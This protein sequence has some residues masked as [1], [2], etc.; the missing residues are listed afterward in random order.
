MPHSAAL[1]F[2]L[3]RSSDVFSGAGKRLAGGADSGGS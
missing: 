3:K 1:P 2:L